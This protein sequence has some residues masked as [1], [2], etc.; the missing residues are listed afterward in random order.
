MKTIKAFCV[1]SPD[2]EYPIYVFASTHNEAKSMVAN[3]LC[4]GGYEYYELNCN[5]L[6]RLDRHATPTR[7]VLYPGTAVSDRIYYESGWLY[8]D[9]PSCDTCGLGQ[10]ESI[11]ESTVEDRPDIG[12]ERMCLSCY[13]SAK[14]TDE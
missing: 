5:R 9:E 7:S 6:P 13:K 12:E 3:E 1:R 2:H 4:V 14:G 8:H 10:F 11:P